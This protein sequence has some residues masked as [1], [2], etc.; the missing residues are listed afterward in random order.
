[1]A[2]EMG[3][4]LVEGRV[5]AERERAARGLPPGEDPG[6]FGPDG[7]AAGF[8]AWVGGG[9]GAAVTG[10]VE[11]S[12]AAAASRRGATPVAVP[13]GVGSA[14]QPLLAAAMPPPRVLGPS[15]LGGAGAIQTSPA[16]GSSSME[17]SDAAAPA[18]VEDVRVLTVKNYATSMRAPDFEETVE[19]VTRDPWPDTAHLCLRFAQEHGGTPNGW[20]PKWRSDGTSAVTI[21]VMQELSKP[22]S[23]AHAR[24]NASRSG[25]SRGSVATWSRPRPCRT[26]ACMQGQQLEHA[27]GS[28]RAAGLDRSRTQQGVCSGKG[29]S[30][31]E[32][33]KKPGKAKVWG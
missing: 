26:R 30:E 22:Q 8:G 17:G 20:H 29:L 7:S 4:L 33:G 16:P 10:A 12:A 13:S 11:H 25:G 15:C 6:P 5:A 2:A 28:T 19:A 1:M 21:N 23:I 24:S 32:R 14:G 9:G 18:S 3:A 27:F 31:R